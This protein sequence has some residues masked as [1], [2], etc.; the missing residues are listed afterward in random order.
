MTTELHVNINIIQ[1]LQKL[2]L[3]Y[4]NGQIDYQQENMWHTV[5]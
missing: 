3:K 5:I 4:N 1:I 2:S